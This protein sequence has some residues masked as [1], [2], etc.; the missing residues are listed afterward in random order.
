MLTAGAD[1]GQIH[2]V[3][4]TATI[5]RIETACAAMAAVVMSAV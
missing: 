2:R 5:L 3:R 4:L 1:A